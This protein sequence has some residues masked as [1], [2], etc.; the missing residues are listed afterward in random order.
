MTFHR[1]APQQGRAVRAPGPDDQ[2]R[3]AIYSAEAGNHPTGWDP[4]VACRA[5]ALS[6]R[7]GP[8]LQRKPRL[9]LIARTHA[10]QG[11]LA[12]PPK[13]AAPAATGG[14]PEFIF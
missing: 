11:A 2:Q 1:A 5:R 13:Q 10:V 6:R 12:R 8:S 14:A 9:P 4:A 7:R 3:A